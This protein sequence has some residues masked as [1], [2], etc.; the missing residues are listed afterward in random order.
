MIFK[1]KD[2]QCIKNKVRNILIYSKV[3]LKLD[4]IDIITIYIIISISNFSS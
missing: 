1:R 2:N 3:N 4:I